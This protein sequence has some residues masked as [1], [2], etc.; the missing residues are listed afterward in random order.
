VILT[1]MLLIGEKIMKNEI[2]S[3]LQRS[4]SSVLNGVNINEAA[5]N[6]EDYTL[7]EIAKIQSENTQKLRELERDLE[8]FEIDMEASNQ[9]LID[10]LA[11]VVL[12]KD[13]HSNNPVK[14]Q[15]LNTLIYK[16]EEQI[17]SNGK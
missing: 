14:Y 17:L 16:A 5:R 6:I 7:A 3:L 9:L 11:E 10:L 4:W 1:K 13:T 15:Y 12:F 8:S 2:K